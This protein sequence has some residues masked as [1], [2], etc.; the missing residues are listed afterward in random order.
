MFLVMWYLNPHDKENRTPVILGTSAIDFGYASASALLRCSILKFGIEFVKMEVSK[1]LLRLS[2]YIDNFNFEA[3][4]RQ[5]LADII[6]D[7]KQNLSKLDLNMNKLY[8]PKKFYYS[9]EFVK[10]RE[11]YPEH[12]QNTVSMGVHWSL[13][14]DKIAPNIRLSLHGSIRGMPR[15]EPLSKVK[16]EETQLTRRHLTR[17]TP[18]LY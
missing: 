11:L 10:V 9:E 6:V 15:G 14:D 8:I 5:E 12:K 18:G 16:W 7:V 4:N 3:R 13:V 2:S 17:L 1:V